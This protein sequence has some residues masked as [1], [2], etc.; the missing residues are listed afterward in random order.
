MNGALPMPA[1]STRADL[2]KAR[3]AASVARSTYAAFACTG[4]P[5]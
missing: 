2:G 3:R 1:V 4:I 5:Q